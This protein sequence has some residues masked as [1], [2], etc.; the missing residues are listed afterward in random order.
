MTSSQS[1]TGMS[2][3]K[4][5]AEKRSRLRFGQELAEMMYAFGDDPQPLPE[6]V[7]LMEALTIEYMGSLARAAL[8]STRQGKVLRTE[9]LLT[10]LRHD[11]TKCYQAT[12]AIKKYQEAQNQESP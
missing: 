9:D 6:S 2:D 3:S 1:V 5:K 11:A 4:K 8:S 10:A 12:L 7:A